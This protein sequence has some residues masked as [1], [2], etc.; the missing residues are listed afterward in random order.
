MIF[1]FLGGT[2]KVQ[3]LA[4]WRLCEK[5]APGYQRDAAFWPRPPASLLEVH[6]KIIAVNI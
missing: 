6:F 4:S 5:P 3:H 1:V 2:M